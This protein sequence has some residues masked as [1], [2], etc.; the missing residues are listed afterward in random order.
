MYCAELRRLFTLL[1]TLFF[2]VATGLW[3]TAW[4]TFRVKVIN[5][6]HRL[7]SLL[8]LSPFAQMWACPTANK[9]DRMTE[10]GQNSR[11]IELQTLL[12][13]E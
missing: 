6:C 2:S 12:L 10:S 13:T 1:F 8:L 11:K 9:D 3:A 7:V 4:S 5:G